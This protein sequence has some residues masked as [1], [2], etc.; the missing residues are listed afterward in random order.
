M[1]I[2]IQMTA[3]QAQNR[4]SFI[5]V[6]PFDPGFLEC[7]IIIAAKEDACRCQIG[8]E[9]AVSDIFLSRLGVIP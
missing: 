8:R 9:I 1:T 3:P 2:I 7:F 6:T 4:C 5:A